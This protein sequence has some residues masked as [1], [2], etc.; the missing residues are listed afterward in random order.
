M[1]APR[2]RH[3]FFVD[4]YDADRRFLRSSLER[5]SASKRSAATFAATVPG[6]AYFEVRRTDDYWRVCEG[7]IPPAAGEAP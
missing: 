5:A 3:T 1:L 6:C 7:T 2:P 4:C